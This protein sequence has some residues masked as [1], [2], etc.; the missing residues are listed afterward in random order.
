MSNGN[1]ESVFW[2]SM[3]FSFRHS[4]VI[5]WSQPVD[6]YSFVKKQDDTLKT[7]SCATVQTR[8]VWYAPLQDWN[9][10][11]PPTTFV[12]S[13]TTAPDPLGTSSSLQGSPQD[14]MCLVSTCRAGCDYTKMWLPFTKQRIC[15]MNCKM[16]SDAA[17]LPVVFYFLLL[18]QTR[19]LKHDTESPSCH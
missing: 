17:T 3:D 9:N 13:H 11:F 14:G 4:S 19:R 5:R 7:C 18:Q 8:C 16:I 6:K 10:S 12:H 15:K 1:E 2:R